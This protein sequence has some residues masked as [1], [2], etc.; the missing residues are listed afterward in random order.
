MFILD[1][2]EVNT[3]MY[4]KGLKAKSDIELWHKRVGHINLCKLRSMQTK[5]VV[6]GFQP[7]TL[8]HPDNVCDVCQL[9][10]QHRHPFLSERNMSKGL[11]DVIQSDV[12]A[13]LKQRQSVGAGTS[14]PSLTTIRSIRGYAR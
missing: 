2:T 11:L 12:S 14:L 9:G 6:H 3:P 7:F 5:G 8:K 1:A 4:A 13:Q 10:K